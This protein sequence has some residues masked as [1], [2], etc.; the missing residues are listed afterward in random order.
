MS[1]LRFTML[2]LIARTRQLINDQ[3]GPAQVF[4][5]TD[6]QDVLDASRADVKNEPMIPKPTFSGSTIQFLDYYTQLGDWEDDAIFKQYLVTP[7]TPSVLE[8]I[9]GHWSFAQTTLP[10]VY[11]SGKTYDIYRAA[12]DLLERMAAQWVMRYNMTVNGQSLQRGQVVM[13]LQALA[14]TYRAKQRATMSTLIRTDIRNASNMA[15]T[16]LGPLE[17]DYM[18]DGKGH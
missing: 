7:V 17:I 8:P 15:G 9:A 14:K 6:I 13:A 12:A 3:P 5:D 1:V 11:I 10:P 16:G 2:N 4:Q 18:A